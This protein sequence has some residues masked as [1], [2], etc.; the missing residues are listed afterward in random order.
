MLCVS[1]GGHVDSIECSFPASLQGRDL[2]VIPMDMFKNCSQFPSSE[3]RTSSSSC[4]S[5]SEGLIISG[6]S[7]AACLEQRPRAVNLRRAPTT[8]VLARLVCGMV[9]LMMV[10]VAMCSCIYAI[11]AA[12]YKQE[13]LKRSL[14]LHQQ[15]LTE[16]KK[17][18]VKHEKDED[19]KK[20]EPDTDKGAKA[21][22]HCINI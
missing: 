17:Q 2:R 5:T 13:Q 15:P 8:L 7:R 22:E 16:V 10:V 1:V 6:D 21:R 20:M 18:E 14:S 19:E 3:I 9:W 12:K 4:S 11:L